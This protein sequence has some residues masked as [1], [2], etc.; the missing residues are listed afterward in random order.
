MVGSGERRRF[1]FPTCIGAGVL[2]VALLAAALLLAPS[3][4]PAD[5]ECGVATGL[6]QTRTCASTSYPDGIW[7]HNLGGVGTAY[8]F[9][10]TGS[11]ATTTI[12]ATGSGGGAG[13]R[14][15]GIY[16]HGGNASPELWLN[17]GGA[18]GGVAHVVNIV[19]GATTSNSATRNN[20]IYMRQGRPLTHT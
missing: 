3:P 13:Q 5:N 19:Q 10:V 6:G 16:T 1:F 18:T 20:G 7:Y 8:T 9:N 11:T 4:A 15:V 12:T 14:S 17:V 2:G